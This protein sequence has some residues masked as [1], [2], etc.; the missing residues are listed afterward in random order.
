MRP[1]VLL[2][3]PLLGLSLAAETCFDGPGGATA[4]D[5][6]AGGHN[7]QW[8]K[9]LCFRLCALDVCYRYISSNGCR[10]NGTGIWL[11]RQQQ[12]FR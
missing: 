12:N 4:T 9:A 7:L 5:A 10:K 2:L 1:L 6:K 3:F 8:T 11:I